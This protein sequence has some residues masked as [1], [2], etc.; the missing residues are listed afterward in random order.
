MQ[1]LFEVK[2]YVFFFKKIQVPPK[3][4]TSRFLAV[5]PPA[6]IDSYIVQ[7]CEN[8]VV[9]IYYNRPRQTSNSAIKSEPLQTVLVLWYKPTITHHVMVR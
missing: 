5:D 6:A 1:V 2:F 3:K 4:S 9:S 7:L 8:S